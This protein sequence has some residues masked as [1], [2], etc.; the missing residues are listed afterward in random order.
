MNMNNMT[1]GTLGDKETVNDL[2]SSQ[3]Y[4]SANLNTFAG[5]CVCEQLRQDMLNILRDEHAIQAE[6]F[7]E[8]NARGWYPV[9]QAPPAE[10]STVRQK[11]M[12]Q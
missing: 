8:A 7:N 10:I 2:L 4:L 12:G 6:L 11:F 5:E 3:K 9:K 1:S